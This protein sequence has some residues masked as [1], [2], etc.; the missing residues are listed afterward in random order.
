[1]WELNLMYATTE[2]ASMLVQVLQRNNKLGFVMNDE[3]IAYGAYVLATK[4]VRGWAP[5]RHEL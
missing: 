2:L 1:M 5:L 4:F 3:Q